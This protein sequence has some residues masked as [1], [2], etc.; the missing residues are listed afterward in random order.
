M[1]DPL[2]SLLQAR[3][4]LIRTNKSI[5]TGALITPNMVLTCAHVIRHAAD[6]ITSIEVLLPDLTEPG[7]F[8]WTETAQEL[9]MSKKYEESVE[10]ENG[11]G[12]NEGVVLTT[13]YPD[14]A[15]IEI[16]QS[17]DAFLDFPQEDTEAATN[18]NAQF[19]AFGFQK[20]ERELQRNVPQAVSLNYSGEQVDGI[21]RKLI[22]SN[23]LIRP[24]MSGA[25][26]LDRD[27]G[28]IVGIVHKTLNP[29]DDLGAY[30]IPVQT[31]WDVFEKWENEGV[32]NLY[33]TLQSSEH[34]R[35]IKKQYREAYP[36]FPLLNRY[37]IRLLIMPALIFLLFWW[38][39][40]HFG[41]IG[42]SGI[43]SLILVVISIFGT[44]LGSWLGEGVRNESDALRAKVGRFL[45]GNAFLISFAAAILF[46]WA[47]VS[48]V[49]IHGNVSF[50]EEIPIVFE[51]GPELSESQEK[52]L[53]PIGVTRFLNFTIP[54]VGDSVALT[55][56]GMTQ[57]KFV[58]NSFSKE[59]FYYPKSFEREPVLI[60][61]FDPKYPMRKQMDKYRIEVAVERTKSN[62]K[63]TPYEFSFIPEQTVGTMFIGKRALSTKEREAEWEEELRSD[64]RITN[65]VIIKRFMDAWKNVKRFPEVDLERNDRISVKVIKISNDSVF[66]KQSY[67]I[68]GDQFDRLLEIRI[69]Q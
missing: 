44:L 51:K 6:D 49:W 14:V 4:V 30:V 12:Q 41:S 62:K 53:G 13:E 3:I 15:V 19:L 23:G 7:H 9:Y 47:F 39:L 27:S 32:N 24:G 56:Q 69:N 5:G 35:Q 40:F 21:I 11:T 43:T 50:D 45:F 33:S 31:I 63:E 38:I 60:L 54:F 48:S 26:L 67:S 57:K 37:G 66:N 29:N 25:P 36:S 18:V 68:K 65:T 61:R 16:S 20:K 58:V 28:S 64:Q 8:L 52:K 1:A 2:I 17:K 22:F 55:P 34:R 42:D 10:P 46:L 59:E